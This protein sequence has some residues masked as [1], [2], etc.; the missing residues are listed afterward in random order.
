M[1]RVGRKAP[2]G[3]IYHVINRGNGR[4]KLF[5]KPADYDA[6]VALLRGVAAVVPVKILAYCLMPNHWHLVLLPPGDGDL[7]KFML[8]LTTTH[9]R[10]YFAHYHRSAGGHLYQGRFKSFAVQEDDEAHLL[11]LLRYVESNALRARLVRDPAQWKWCS[12]AARQTAAGMKLLSAWPIERPRNWAK[13]LAERLPEKEAEALR[14]SVRRG[15][16]FGSPDW[17]ERTAR[18]LGL[19]FTLR[20]RGRPRT[21]GERRK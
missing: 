10:R 19:D 16:P 1:P 3:V 20:P 7:S 4:Q 15:R 17:V 5:H 2:G 18:R 14:V 13:L 9:V 6:F 12:F 8:R 11:V 21:A